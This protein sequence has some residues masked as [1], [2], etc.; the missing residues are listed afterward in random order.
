MQKILLAVD[1]SESCNK[2]IG[3]VVDLAQDVNS[4]I[5]VL[6][7]IEEGLSMQLG[8][9]KSQVESE[10]EEMEEVKEKG[11]N[12][13][14]NC[15]DAFNDIAKINTI[16]KNG[17]PAASICE[18]AKSGDYDFVVVADKGH[19]AVKKFFLGS[20]TEKVVRHCEKTVMVV[21]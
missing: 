8:A 15:A 1:G 7:V 4:E 16:T 12:A 18:E 14:A 19:S 2:A 6:T 13:V 3:K 17:N 20:T 5:T 21:K 10:V 11:I 9:S